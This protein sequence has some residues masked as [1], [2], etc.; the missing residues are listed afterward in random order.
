VCRLAEPW[1]GSDYSMGIGKASERYS[2]PPRRDPTADQAK[3]FLDIGVRHFPVG[4][5]ITFMHQWWKMQGEDM[6]KALGGS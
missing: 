1:S 6:R 5:D 2:P 3:Y 4:T